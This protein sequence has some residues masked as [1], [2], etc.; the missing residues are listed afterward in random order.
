MSIAGM[1]SRHIRSLRTS[2]LEGHEGHLQVWTRVAVFGPMQMSLG[3]SGTSYQCHP[4]CGVLF[5]V[6]WSPDYLPSRQDSG[7]DGISHTT[8]HPKVPPQEM[9]GSHTTSVTGRKQ[10]FTGRGRVLVQCRYC[11]RGRTCQD[12]GRSKERMNGTNFEKL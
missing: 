6:V 7:T 4:M 12:K 3:A 10:F 5:L 2:V 1:H 11:P 8:A 9:P